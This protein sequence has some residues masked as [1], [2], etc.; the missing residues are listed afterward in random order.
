MDGKEERL[1]LLLRLV[2][3]GGA[4]TQAD[5]LRGLRI[6]GER[7][8]QSTL[9]RD[10]AELG[11]RKAGGR[12]VLPAG[13]ERATSGRLSD[14]ASAVR[15]FTPC[16]PH[17]VILAT[18]AGRAPSVAAALDEARESAVVATLAGDDTLFIATRNRRTQAVV[19]RRLKQWF[20]ANKDEQRN[21]RAG[22]LGRAGHL[23]HRG[24]AR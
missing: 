2:S 8:D 24:V 5:L 19:L 12:Y 20:G 17:L 22:V 18:T 11:V 10:L 16:G 21:V 1:A 4:R 13:A 14:Y 15:W 3:G 9:S 6:R 23:D 7:I